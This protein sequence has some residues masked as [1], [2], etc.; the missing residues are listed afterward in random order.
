MWRSDGR[1]TYWCS[2][3]SNIVFAVKGGYKI[4]SSKLNI[5]WIQYGHAVSGKLRDLYSHSL[6]KLNKHNIQQL[7]RWYIY[8]GFNSTENKKWMC[9]FYIKKLLLCVLLWTLFAVSAF[10]PHYTGDRGK[11]MIHFPFFPPFERLI[12]H[13]DVYV[14]LGEYVKDDCMYYV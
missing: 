9:S 13:G 3:P 8:E 11:R 14:Q 5:P 4:L 10:E 1:W 2:R 7:D 6:I 12:F